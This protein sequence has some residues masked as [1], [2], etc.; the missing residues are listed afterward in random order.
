MEQLLIS[1]T[2]VK[3]SM[4]VTGTVL[5]NEPFGSIIELAEGLRAL[6]PLNHM[7]EFQRSNPSSKF[8]VSCL[9]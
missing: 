8:Q 3:P 1:T 6:C 4:H 2:D 9:K 5:K 7:S